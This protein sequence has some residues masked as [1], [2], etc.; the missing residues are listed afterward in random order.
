MKTVICKCLNI[1]LENKFL[2]IKN[3]LFD[4]GSIVF[5]L[6]VLYICYFMLKH[7]LIYFNIYNNVHILLELQN[8]FLFILLFSLLISMVYI[9]IKYILMIINLAQIM[10]KEINNEIHL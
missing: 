5:S 10:G 2:F 7:I 9:A 6:F 1:L 8:I 4:F 3:L